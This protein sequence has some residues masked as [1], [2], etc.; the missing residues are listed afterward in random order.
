MLQGSLLRSRGAIFPALIASGFGLQT[1]RRC[2]AAMRYG[3]WQPPELIQAWQGYVH[4]Q[5]AWIEHDH[6]GY[7]A[8]AVDLTAFW[9][10]R[11]KGWLGKHFHSLAGRALPAVAFGVVVWVGQIGSQRIPLL[12]GLVRADQ[13]DP[14]EATLTRKLLAQVGQQLQPDEIALFDAGFKLA[15]LQAA[16]IKQGVIRLAINVTAYRNYPAPYKGRGRYPVYGEIVRPLTRTH[17]GKQIPATAPDFISQFEY[18]GRTIKVKGWYD[19][20]LPGVM[21][22]P[23]NDTFDVYVFEDPL[24]REPLILA[25]TLRLRP[26]TSFGLYQDRW[27]VEQV[28][29]AAK[30]MIG[31]HR[32]FVFAYQSCQRLP[33]LALIA[34]GVLSYLAAVLPPIPTGFWDTQPKATP[35]RL[36]RLLAKADFPEDYPFEPQLRKKC[37]LTTHLPKGAA[38]HRRIKAVH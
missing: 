7:R 11:L 30:Q 25:A 10:P 37:S 24:Y 13:A 1:A 2:W 16:Q 4:E 22:G 3:Y 31:A 34:G 26:V 9:R 15:A 33:E 27:P 35:G 8:V 19:L 21:P 23:A 6:A 5:G 20:I 12:K 28:P 17:K 36:R 18:H 29:L 38:A 32:Q 14:S